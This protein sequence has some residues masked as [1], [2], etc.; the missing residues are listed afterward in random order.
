MASDPGCTPRK[1]LKFYVQMPDFWCTF[2]W[3]IYSRE[4]AKYHTFPI[5]AILCAPSTRNITKQDNWHRGQD[6][7][8]MIQDGR[9]RKWDVPA[10][11]GWVAMGCPNSITNC[12]AVGHPVFLTA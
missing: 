10:K 12:D 9:A 7:D 5:Q 11:I 4:S 1:I 6:H 2:S 3:K 8:R